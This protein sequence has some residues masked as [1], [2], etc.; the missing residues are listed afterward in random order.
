MILGS[1]I[2]G[3]GIKLEGM[4]LAQQFGNTQYIEPIEMANKY[5]E[6]LKA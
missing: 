3:L 1:A 4:V 2:L 6:I 5:A